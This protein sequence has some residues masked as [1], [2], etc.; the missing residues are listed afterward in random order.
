MKKRFP[1][2]RITYYLIKPKKFEL[3]LLE[4]KMLKIILAMTCFF[5]YQMR[6]IILSKQIF[7]FFS[8]TNLSSYSKSRFLIIYVRFD[9]FAGGYSFFFVSDH[10]E[11][12]HLSVR[13]YSLIKLANKSEISVAEMDCVVLMWLVER[14]LGWFGR[15]IFNCQFNIGFESCFIEAHSNENIF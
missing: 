1:H 14:V 12:L 7:S 10:F 9:H 6:K 2:V 11:R 4:H 3:D 5:L 13:P 8:K 15:T